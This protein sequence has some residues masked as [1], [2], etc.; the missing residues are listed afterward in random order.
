MT[1]YNY[2][3]YFQDTYLPNGLEDSVLR[4]KIF[5]A[6]NGDICARNEVIENNTKLV[7]YLL[8]YYYNNIFI[9]KREITSI[10][11][12]ALIECVD[13]FDYKNHTSFS[14]S[15]KMYIHNKVVNYLKKINRRNKYT[16][17]NIEDISNIEDNFI[18]GE[19]IIDEE[20][21]IRINSYLDNLDNNIKDM[22]YM[23]YGYYG[24]SYTYKVI[25]NKYNLSISRIQQI[26][27]STI[28]DLA[29]TLYKEGYIDNYKEKQH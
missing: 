21:H 10:A 4:N 29:K 28:K 13:N 7:I 19:S 14:N 17:I 27:S 16:L 23:Y 20:I 6:Q 25:A 9:D 1:N 22:L 18:L 26:I 3:D 11:M 5:L 15:L 24:D 12:E 2:K 8:N